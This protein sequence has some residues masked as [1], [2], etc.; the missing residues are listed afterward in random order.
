[1]GLMDTKSTEMKTKILL[2]ALFLIGI[3]SFAQD[4][5]KLSKNLKVTITGQFDKT[6]GLSFDH[7]V[8]DKHGFDE[9]SAAFKTAFA[10]NGLVINDKPRYV[11]T[12]DYK[13]GYVIAAY[14]FQYSNLTAQ[15]LDLSNNKTIVGTITYSG[16]FDL[17]PLGNGIAVELKK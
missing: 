2:L 13:Y 10:N 1:M 16:R 15:I 7:S 6:A 17:D 4:A 11:I 14:K 8:A 9:I 3:N 5:K 12:M